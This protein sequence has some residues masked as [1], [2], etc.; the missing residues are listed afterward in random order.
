MLN[1]NDGMNFQ[2]D[3]RATRDNYQELHSFYVKNGNANLLQVLVTF[4]EWNHN[5]I[6]HS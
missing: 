2:A 1:K 3:S 4:Q 6:T 5:D